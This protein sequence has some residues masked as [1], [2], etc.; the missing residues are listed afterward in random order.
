RVDPFH[1]APPVSRGVPPED[2]G[3]GY[4]TLFY[5]IGSPAARQRARPGPSTPRGSRRRPGQTQERARKH[6]G[7]SATSGGTAAEMIHFSSRAGAAAGRM[8]TQ[9][10][11]NPSP[12]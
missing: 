2:V 10:D 3:M 8:R 9:D 4:G 12:G 7:N 6:Q 1:H 11:L 5:V